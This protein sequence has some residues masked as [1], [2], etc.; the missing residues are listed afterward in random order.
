LRDLDAVAPVKAPKVTPAQKRTLEAIR[1]NGI[2]ISEFRV[3]KA[4]VTAEHGEC[5]RRDMILWVIEQGW[6]VRDQSTS[7]FQGQAIGLTEIGTAILAG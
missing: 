2:K 5:P 4:T 6:A 7:L 1:G 3:G